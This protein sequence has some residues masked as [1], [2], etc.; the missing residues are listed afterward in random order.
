[1]FSKKNRLIVLIIISMIIAIILGYG[2]NKSITNNTYKTEQTYIQK[3]S[4]GNTE[5]EKAIEL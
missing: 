4:K 2:I 3:I 1:M 5:I